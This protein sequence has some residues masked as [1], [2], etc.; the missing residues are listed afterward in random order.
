MSVLD[1]TKGDPDKLFWNDLDLK[2]NYSIRNAATHCITMN[3]ISAMVS[4]I[5]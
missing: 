3:D 4:L 2:S 1:G 5:R